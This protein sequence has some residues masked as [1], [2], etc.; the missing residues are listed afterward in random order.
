MEVLFH[1]RENGEESI[2][3]IAEVFHCLPGLG[4]LPLA[5]NRLLVRDLTDEYSADHTTL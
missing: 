2:V 4:P 5:V 1:C 3:W